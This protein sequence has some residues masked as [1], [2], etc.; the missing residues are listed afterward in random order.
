MYLSHLPM[1]SLFWFQPEF[2]IV[3]LY[4][5]LLC[6]L[7]FFSWY[8]NPLYVAVCFNYSKLC[9]PNNFTSLTLFNKLSTSYYFSI[10]SPPYIPNISQYLWNVL[11]APKIN[12]VLNMHACACLSMDVQ[13][14]V[15]TWTVAH[16]MSQRIII[17]IWSFQTDN[18]LI[19]KFQRASCMM[20]FW[21]L[22]SLQR[23]V[24]LSNLLDFKTLEVK[25]YVNITYIP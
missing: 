2:S 10:C 4:L 18:I 8:Q 24:S 7:T 25:V 23:I 1:Q 9:I 14:F 6:L 13:L 22:F 21:F 5:T 19:T 17:L 15:T 16:H 11:C 20:E 12:L 3:V